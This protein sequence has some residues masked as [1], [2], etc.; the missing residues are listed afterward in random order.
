[1]KIVPMKP[2]PPI[3]RTAPRDFVSFG[4]AAIGFQSGDFVQ[5]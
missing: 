2:H 3:T 1:M 4:L 5:D